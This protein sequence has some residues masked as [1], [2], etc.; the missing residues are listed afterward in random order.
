MTTSPP[1]AVSS[2]APSAQ[3]PSSYKRG[4]TSI[5]AERL[6]AEIGAA[7]HKYQF[8]DL[9]FQDETFFTYP[10]RVM[11][12]ADEFLRRD[13]KF[14]WTATMRADQGVRLNDEG[15][16]LCVKSGMRRVMIGVEAGSQEMMDWMQ[17]DI[18]IEQVIESAEMCVRHGVGAIFPFI[19]GFPGETD[20]SIQASLAMVKQLRAM[21]PQI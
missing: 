1:P 5:D 12:I 7:W 10:H 4:W 21:S 9:S 18:K 3:T 8:T 19:V 6:G 17:K 20:K 15:F 2:G 16:A 14:T 13:L 11:A